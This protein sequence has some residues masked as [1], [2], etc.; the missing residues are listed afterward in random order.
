M[1]DQHLRSI[2]RNTKKM[3]G[4]TSRN[5]S[6]LGF[7]EQCRVKFQWVNPNS[8]MWFVHMWDP[9]L[10]FRKNL[11]LFTTLFWAWYGT[12]LPYGITCLE[13]TLVQ[14]CH[15]AAREGSWT[16]STGM[17]RWSETTPPWHRQRIAWH[18]VTVTSWNEAANCVGG[19]TA[20]S[21]FHGS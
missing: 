20:I 2:H 4:W 8:P 18:L 14:S 3:K 6:N 11:A 7:S 16:S 1:W 9:M 10:E 17:R 19:L 5:P 15:T 13:L 21:P 12:I